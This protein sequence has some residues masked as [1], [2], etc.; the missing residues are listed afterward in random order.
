MRY[1]HERGI[2]HRDL[3]PANVLV[4]S[5]HGDQSLQLKLCDF[6]LAKVI[7]TTKLDLPFETSQAMPRPNEPTTMGVDK[8]A[9][10]YGTL[11]TEIGTPVYMAPELLLGEAY[12]PAKR[13][14]YAFAILIWSIISAGAF[15]YQHLKNQNHF[16]VLLHVSN[17]GRPTVDESWSQDL[18]ALM[19]SCWAA[20]A[21][22][23]PSFIQISEQADVSLSLV[24]GAEPV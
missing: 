23:R 16:H 7:S 5:S 13:D 18:Q 2:F 1:L 22:S 14:S 10:G 19:C 4:N 15:P 21:D 3:K 9:A 17:G 8:F 24:G 20:D 11:T 6:G 12:D